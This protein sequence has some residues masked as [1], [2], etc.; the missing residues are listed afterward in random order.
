MKLNKLT[1]NYLRALPAVSHI[2]ARNGRIY[3]TDEFR[4]ECVRRYRNG[5][6]PAK[7]FRDNGLGSEIIG[8]KRIERCMA[9]WRNDDIDTD[10]QT[11]PAPEPPNTPP[12]PNNGEDDERYW[13]IPRLAAHI[14]DLERRVADLERT[15]AEK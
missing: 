12:S 11:D 10:R 1:I 14:R 7:I 6:R 4:A 13:T 8:A 9:R 15:E 3:Y 2:D 5:E